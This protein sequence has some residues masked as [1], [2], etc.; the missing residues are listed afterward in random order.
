MS[1]DGKIAL[2]GLRPASC[3]GSTGSLLH[4][5][6]LANPLIA[7]GR[8]VCVDRSDADVAVAYR[9]AHLGQR[10]PANA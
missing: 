8:H 1:E 9:V 10:P 5:E 3:F 6:Q 7:I 2:H 4:V